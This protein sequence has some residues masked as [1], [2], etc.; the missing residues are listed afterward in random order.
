MVFIQGKC[1]LMCLRE[2]TENEPFA[3]KSE[4]HKILVMIIDSKLALKGHAKNLCKKASQKI[5]TLTRRSG[6]LMTHRR[7]YNIHIDNKI[8]I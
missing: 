8:S 1:Y 6:F 3:F 4:E 7:P 2:N 5:S